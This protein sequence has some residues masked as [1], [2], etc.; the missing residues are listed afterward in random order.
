[1]TR[2]LSAGER[3]DH[4]AA[5][6]QDDQRRY[7][8]I[9]QAAIQAALSAGATIGHHHGVGRL[10]APFLIDE[11]GEG[12]AIA[13][14]VMALAAERQA[15]RIDRAT[16]VAQGASLRE[17]MSSNL[18]W[19]ARNAPGPKARAM[20]RELLKVE[21]LLWTFLA[22]KD[23]SVTNNH[24]ERLLRYP[25]IWRKLS[26]GTRSESGALYVERLLTVTMSLRLQNRNAFDYLK[27]AM[28]AHSCG[29]PV[30]SILLLASVA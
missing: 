27:D 18:G 9:W 28:T 29:K 21:D 2:A 20:A 1:M 30:P 8:E 11:H 23:V 3:D 15:G 22:H 26:F 10:R 24:A 12:S 4:S 17:Q 6:L 7:D 19:T 14:A 13:R 5:R 16:F 25:V